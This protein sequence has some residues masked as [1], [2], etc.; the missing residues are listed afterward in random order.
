MGVNIGHMSTT[1]TSVNVSVQS[2]NF[3]IQVSCI[4][5]SYYLKGLLPIFLSM[6]G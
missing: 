6:E 2:L 4:K 5:Y 3:F 1:T